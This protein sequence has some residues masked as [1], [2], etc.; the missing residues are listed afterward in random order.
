MPKIQAVCE[1]ESQSML[2]EGYGVGAS[3]RRGAFKKRPAVVEGN[4]PE[5]PE[6][7]RPTVKGSSRKSLFT[8]EKLPTNKHQWSVE[9]TSALIQYICLF[10]EDADTDRWP[11]QRDKYSSGM[12]VLMQ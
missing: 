11:M 9:E 10:W 2:V 12:T 6:K 4:T 5:K 8:D 1:L 7:K 3:G